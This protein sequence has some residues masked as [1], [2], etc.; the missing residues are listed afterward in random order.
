MQRGPEVQRGRRG[1]PRDVIS[2]PGVDIMSSLRGFDPVEFSE[3]IMGSAMISRRGG[4]RGGLCPDTQ[5]DLQDAAHG[6]HPEDA[7]SG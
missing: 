6:D 7:G 3:K 2:D 1:D 4:Y 5:E